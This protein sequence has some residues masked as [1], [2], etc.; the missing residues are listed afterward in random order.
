MRATDTCFNRMRAKDSKAA[1]FGLL[2]AVRKAGRQLFGE[3]TGTYNA[4][5]LSVGCT[6]PRENKYRIGTLPQ[7]NNEGADNAA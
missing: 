6:Y 2:G 1:S 4:E 5:N 7:N 3:L